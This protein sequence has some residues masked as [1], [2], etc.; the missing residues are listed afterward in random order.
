MKL[1]VVTVSVINVTFKRNC[2]PFYKSHRHIFCSW[3]FALKIRDFSLGWIQMEPV[4]PGGKFSK[5]M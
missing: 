1:I 4:R 3:S 5:A 2:S